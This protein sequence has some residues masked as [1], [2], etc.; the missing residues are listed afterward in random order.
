MSV[1]A[2]IKN[3]SKI[4]QKLFMFLLF[5]CPGTILAPSCRASCQ[6]SSSPP[7]S[8]GSVRAVSSYP[9]SRSTM[10]PTSFCAVDSVPSPSKS[11]PGTRLSPSAALRLALPR[12]PHLAARAAAEDHRVRT[13]VVLPKPSGSRFQTR[14]FLHLPIRRC[15]ETVPEPFSYPTKRFLHAW[16]Q[17]HVTVNKPVL[18]YLLYCCALL[19]KCV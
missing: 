18:L 10:A 11:G 15:Q 19:H 3:F 17:R 6:P 7:P 4:F 9:F 2:I 14:W 1:D 5:L 13:Q 8:S 12:M 16:D